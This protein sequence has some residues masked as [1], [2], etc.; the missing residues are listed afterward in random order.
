MKERNRFYEFVTSLKIMR[1]EAEATNTN[2]LPVGQR[3]K[4][5]GTQLT[6]YMKNFTEQERGRGPPRICL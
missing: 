6:Q 4:M 5:T 3:A 2:E 1:K